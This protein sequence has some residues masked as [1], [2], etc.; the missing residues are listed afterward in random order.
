MTAST[1]VKEIAKRLLP[2]IMLDIL[3]GVSRDSLPS[4][5]VFG[6]SGDYRSWD[7]AVRASSGYGS[8]IILE[9]TKAALLKVKKG[10]AVY[11]RDSVVLDHVDYAWPLLAGLMWVAGGSGG[12]LDVLDF[13]GSLGSAYFQNRAFLSRLAKV[14]WNI[15]EQPQH[16]S[17]GKE[18]FEDEHLKFYGS[19]E[20]CLAEAEPNV[21]ILGSVL[22]YLEHPYEILC[23]LLEL[24]CSHIIIDRTPFWNGP[25]DRLCVQNVPPE[26][27]PAS[28]PSWIFSRQRFL[29]QFQERW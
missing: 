16:V 29:S 15:I 7:E 14:R 10:E 19:V 22:Q 17:T 4:E 5:N 9:R 28:Y 25:R 8:C 13:G 1:R 2:P 23:R 27:Y 12:K 24:P 18:F 21:L 6:L 3:K 20:D 11:E 26:I